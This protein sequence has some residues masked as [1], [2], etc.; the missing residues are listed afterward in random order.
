MQENIFK[1]M[2]NSKRNVILKR[3]FELFATKNY[4]EVSTDKITSDANVAKGLLF[5]YFGSKKELYLQLVKMVCDYILEV[6]MHSE[7]KTYDFYESV[8]FILDEQFRMFNTYSFEFKFIEQVKQ[9]TSKTVYKEVSLII[10][11]FQKEYDQYYQEI[12]TKSIL[13]LDLKENINLTQLSKALLIYVLAI[14]NIYIRKYVDK[15]KSF[16]IDSSLIKKEINTYL[17]F[18]VKGITI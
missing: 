9:E 2:D 1:S 12:I 13:N 11:Q 18:M 10:E 4:Q 14:N 8:Y 5:H 3:A 15:P 17:D 6:K 7:Y 16:F